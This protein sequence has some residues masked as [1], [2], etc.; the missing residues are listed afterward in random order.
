MEENKNFE[1][2]NLEQGQTP[3]QEQDKNQNLNQAGTKTAEQA[4]QEELSKAQSRLLYT[5]A[6]FENYKKRVSKE[7]KDWIAIAQSD[8]LLDFLPIQDDIGRALEHIKK[9][10]LSPEQEKHLVGFELIAKEFVKLLEK[11]QIQEIKELETFDPEIHEALM[12]VESPSHKPGQ[13]IN[14]L[15]KGYK[16]KDRIIRPAKVSVAK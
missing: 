15:Q 7:K 12:Q 9:E 8:V 11:Y 2:T 4:C 1:D 3:N 5:I 10:K 16:H 6:E 14:I 13:I